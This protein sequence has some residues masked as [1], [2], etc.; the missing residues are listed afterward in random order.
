MDSLSE[1]RQF[2]ERRADTEVDWRVD[3]PRNG[4]QQDLSSLYS[5]VRIMLC[6]VYLFMEG[7][8]QIDFDPDE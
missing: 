8:V 3:V 6:A 4:Y 1:E 7:L 2:V 5:L